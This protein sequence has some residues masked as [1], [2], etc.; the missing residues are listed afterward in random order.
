[1]QNTIYFSIPFC[2]KFQLKSKCTILSVILF[3]SSFTAYSQVNDSNSFSTANTEKYWNGSNITA[4]A[5]S[6]AST[7]LFII[8]GIA[9]SKYKEQ[10]EIAE[11][12]TG[13]FIPLVGS[14]EGLLSL[15]TGISGGACSFASV[16]LWAKGYEKNHRLKVSPDISLKLD[17]RFNNEILYFGLRISES[18]ERPRPAA[19]NQLRNRS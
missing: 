2:L 6:I 11:D 16:C 10:M 7:G 1:M 9:F 4:G 3:L 13:L 15:F 14:L 8:S 17:S 5:L 19:R 18:Y 12:A